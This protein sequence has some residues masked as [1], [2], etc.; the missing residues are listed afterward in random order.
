MYN[1]RERIAL[2]KLLK[3]YKLIT[4]KKLV[5]KK[6]FNGKKKHSSKYPS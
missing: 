4:K 6:Y 5:K 2:P 1:K 3:A